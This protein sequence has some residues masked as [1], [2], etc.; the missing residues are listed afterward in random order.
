MDCD[1]KL[2]GGSVIDGSGSPARRA[3]VAVTGDRITAIGDRA[4]VAAGRT[5]DCTGKT[6][7]PGFMR[8]ASR[9]TP[10]EIGIHPPWQIAATSLR[11]SANSRTSD[12]TLSSRRSL[13]GMKP[14]GMTMP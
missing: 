13:S 8:M 6:I 4:Q 10:A 7:T 5:V 2:S 1:L 11:L 3:D 9:Y 14:P 12:F